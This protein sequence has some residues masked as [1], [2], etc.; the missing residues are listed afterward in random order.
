M[1]EG[2]A[3]KGSRVAGEVV[4]V[5]RRNTV[6]K[7]PGKVTHPARITRCVGGP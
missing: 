3:L 7:A 2:E 1:C 6:S 5:F 4:R